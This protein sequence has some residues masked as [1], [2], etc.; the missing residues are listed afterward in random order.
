VQARLLAGRS[1]DL[2]D[3]VADVVGTCGGV[4]LGVALRRRRGR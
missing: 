1:G 2:W 3:V 4:V